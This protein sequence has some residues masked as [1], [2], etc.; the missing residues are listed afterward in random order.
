MGSSA[1]MSTNNTYIK[2]LI[3]IAQNSQSIANN[4]SS[5]TIDVWIWRTNIGYTT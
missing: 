3:E 4:T 2:Y 1:N 5:V